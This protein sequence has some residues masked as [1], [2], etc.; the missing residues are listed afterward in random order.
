MA[1]RIAN[2]KANRRRWGDAVIDDPRNRC[3][4]LREHNSRLNIGSR[5]VAC[6]ALAAEILQSTSS[7]ER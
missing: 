1:H 6:A 3:V 7:S 2:T 5:P 4:A